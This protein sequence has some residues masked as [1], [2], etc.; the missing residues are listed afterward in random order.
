MLGEMRLAPAFNI[1]YIS[2]DSGTPSQAA[3]R[4]KKGLKIEFYLCFG[5]KGKHKTH[6]GDFFLKVVVDFGDVRR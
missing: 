1:L 3:T 2:S 6:E 5:E 4:Y